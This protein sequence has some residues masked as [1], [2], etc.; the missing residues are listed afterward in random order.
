VTDSAR[1]HTVDDGAVNKRNYDT[2]KGFDKA[3]ETHREQASI[4][5]S[6]FK[7]STRES[8]RH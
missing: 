8:S 4:S 5:E 7:S 3:E 6:D 2:E 1:S